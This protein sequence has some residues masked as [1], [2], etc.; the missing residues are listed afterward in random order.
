MNITPY[1]LV[2]SLVSQLVVTWGYKHPDIKWI[3]KN[4]V[5]LISVAVS[6]VMAVTAAWA[7]G[8][9]DEGTVQAALDAAWNAICGSGLSV[10]FYEWTKRP[11]A[12][13]EA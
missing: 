6:S 9:L 13:V 12:I 10:A 7:S 3:N 4:T 5:K 11:S 1:I 2:T 8:T